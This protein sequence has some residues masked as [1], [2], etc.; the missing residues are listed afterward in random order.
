MINE[1]VGLVTQEE[2]NKVQELHERILGLEELLIS[3]SN[4]SNIQEAK[5]ELYEK[6]VK[7]IGETKRKLQV[8]WDEMYEKY[9]WKTVKNG[10]WHI[11]FLTNEFFLE[12]NNN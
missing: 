11:D 1:K 8:W 6:V 3:F 7:D 5:N 4:K 10:N 2:K 12:F 9:N